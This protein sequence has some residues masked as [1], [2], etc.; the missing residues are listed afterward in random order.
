MAKHCFSSCKCRIKAI[1]DQKQ[2]RL[3]ASY[4]L[5][6]S[7][8]SKSRTTFP[9]GP[10]LGAPQCIE[11]C[12]SGRRRRH[13]AR[14]DGG[15]SASCVGVGGRRRLPAGVVVWMVGED[16]EEDLHG[17]GRELLPLSK[18][19]GALCL[20]RVDYVCNARSRAERANGVSNRPEPRML[21]V[22]RVRKV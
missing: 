10:L 18:L 5:P 8:L 17:T 11:A 1:R 7:P 20:T 21:Q 14:E 16:G 4:L 19:A 12:A 2:A 3:S 13:A 15:G 6:R 9:N 22:V